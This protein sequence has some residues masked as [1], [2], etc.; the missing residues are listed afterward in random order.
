MPELDTAAEVIAAACLSCAHPLVQGAPLRHHKLFAGA[1]NDA[2]IGSPY[3][4]FS[5]LLLGAL[6]RLP[7]LDPATCY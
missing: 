2:A 6:V 7:K 1:G 3:L 5:N 4:R